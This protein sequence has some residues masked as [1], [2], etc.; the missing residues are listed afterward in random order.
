MIYL[1]R[2]L[3]RYLFQHTLKMISHIQETI[4]QALYLQ[5]KKLPD[6]SPGDLVI[7]LF[8][9]CLLPIIRLMIS[10][11]GPD[12]EREENTLETISNRQF[13]VYVRNIIEE[14]TIQPAAPLPND[15]EILLQSFKWVSQVYDAVPQIEE[16]EDIRQGFGN[17]LKGV[18]ACDLILNSASGNWNRDTIIGLLRKIVELNPELAW[19]GERLP[20]QSE[21]KVIPSEGVI[22]TLAMMKIPPAELIANQPGSLTTTQRDFLIAIQNWHVGEI[23]KVEQRTRRWVFYARILMGGV[24]VL[25]F[26]VILAAAYGIRTTMVARSNA[27]MAATNAGIAGEVARVAGTDVV[28]AS[29]ARVSSTQS[30]AT[31]QVAAT[32]VVR[33]NADEL[34]AQSQ[35]Q[36]DKRLDLALLLGIE[37]FRSLD[38][39]QT[40]NALFSALHHDERLQQFIHGHHGGVQALAYSPDGRYLASAGEDR[41]ILISEIS[42]GKTAFTPLTGHTDTIY[43][44]AFSEKGR[45]LASGGRDHRIILWDLSQGK[46]RDINF[47]GHSGSIYGLAFNPDGTRIVSASEDKSVRVW[48]VETGKEIGSPKLSHTQSVTAVAFSPNGQFIASGG[49][50]KQVIIWNAKSGAP[51]SRAFINAIAP[52]WTLAF[53][54]DSR[55]LAAGSADGAIHLWDINKGTSAGKALTGH[56]QNVLGV[57]FSPDGKLLLSAGDDG[58]LVWMLSEDAS[59]WIPSNMLEGEFA[60]LRAVAFSPDGATMAAGSSIDDTVLVWNVQAIFG[61]GYSGGI[62]L[63]SHTDTVSDLVFSPEGSSLVSGSWDGTIRL[64]DVSKGVNSPAVE[65]VSS[66]AVINAHEGYVMSVSVSPDGKW[67]ASGGV[68][69]SVRLWRTS[70]QQPLGAPLMGHEDWVRDVLFQP[71]G[72]LLASAGWDKTVRL[73]DINNQMPVNQVMTPSGKALYSL[74]FNPRG[75][76]LATASESGQDGITVWRSVDFASEVPQKVFSIPM[77]RTI[78]ALDISPDGKILAAGGADKMITLWSI[79]D[80]SQLGN[81]WSAHSGDIL[82]LAFSPDGSLLA[83]GGSDAQVIL[84]DVQTGLPLGR[85]LHG[86]S[87][88]V[89][90]VAFR[91]DGKLLAS[92][93]AD[94]NI[95]LWSTDAE[96]WIVQACKKVGRNFS[97]AEWEKYF[98]SMPYRKTCPQNP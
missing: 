63:A 18:G 13:S 57:D 60:P 16:F 84:W 43:A 56:R 75:D 93:S 51:Y 61:R 21:T 83:S 38:T 1:G 47:E 42:S 12:L 29:T 52:V 68:D 24:A 44:L 95:V 59:Q 67:I 14:F 8:A 40:R 92:G 33:E 76:L 66:R 39:Y 25:L 94:K 69:K 88:F 98:I 23:D 58:I 31:A 71:A 90:A 85:P 5:A 26:A 64:W 53:S 97:Q 50:D 45:L 48:D 19:M 96:E 65:G 28:I 7:F 77:T 32:T 70:N 74:V 37:A 11:Q 17:L 86:H 49:L 35:A 79:E 91:P 27:D 30:I 55:L 41:T 62:T 36:L 89:Y 34:A 3:I 87:D 46:A 2:G 81:G 22:E 20:D 78:Y 15:E 72:S 4:R 54:P 82:D 80:G 73:W 6:Y 10:V 9:Y